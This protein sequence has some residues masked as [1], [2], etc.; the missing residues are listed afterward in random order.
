M[1]AGE[2]QCELDVLARRQLRPQVA[3]LKDDGQALRPVVR[4]L[5]LAEASERDPPDAHVA[6]GGLLETGREAQHRALPGAR[7]PEHRDDLTR[8][9]PQVEAAQRDGLGRARAVDLEDVVE[10]ERTPIELRYPLRLVVERLRGHFSR[11]LWIII[12][13]ASTLSTPTGEP[14]S[15]TARLPFFASS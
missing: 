5:P 15:T 11:K 3:A 1:L 13:Y 14:R 2:S 7:R 6:R 8:L 4:E 12:R 9:D 10:L